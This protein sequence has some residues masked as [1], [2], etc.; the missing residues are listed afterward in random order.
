MD[1]PFISR[2]EDPRDHQFAPAESD[3]LQLCSMLADFRA[4]RYTD[5]ILVAFSLMHKL[6][7]DNL[8]GRRKVHGFH[9]ELMHFLE[10]F[11]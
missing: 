3:L 4:D 1:V 8:E 9:R 10:F 5:W 2:L 6:T 7:S 11:S